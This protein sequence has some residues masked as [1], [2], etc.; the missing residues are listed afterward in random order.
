MPM[1][2]EKKDRI[3]TLLQVFSFEFETVDMYEHDG[4]SSYAEDEEVQIEIEA[5]KD[6]EHTFADAIKELT[7]LLLETD[8]ENLPNDKVRSLLRSLNFDYMLVK[9]DAMDWLCHYE[10]DEEVQ[11]DIEA[12]KDSE[13]AFMAARDELSNLL[14]GKSFLRLFIEK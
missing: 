5:V 3:R 8:L 7:T 2:N 4:V 9:M 13:Q 11:P 1:Q 6:A 14:F 12:V 10:D